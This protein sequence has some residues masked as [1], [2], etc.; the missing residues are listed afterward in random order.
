[1]GLK[2]KLTWSRWPCQSRTVNFIIILAHI[3][4]LKMAKKKMFK[5]NLQKHLS[6]WNVWWVS[7]ILP[8]WGGG[9]MWIYPA[10]PYLPIQ[11]HALWKPRL[12]FQPCTDQTENQ[13]NVHSTLNSNG[14]EW[15]PVE[16]DP[17]ENPGAWDF[18]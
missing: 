13:H 2:E 7:P 14:R 12:V 10:R 15:N 4:W 18:S 3:I 16:Q 11:C 8:T 1:M 9:S 6:K 5:K 17:A